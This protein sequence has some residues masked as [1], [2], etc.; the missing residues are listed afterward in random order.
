MDRARVT[1]EWAIVSDETMIVSRETGECWFLDLTERCDLGP[2]SVPMSG[3]G[4][5]GSTGA[6]LNGA[7]ELGFAPDDGEMKQSTLSLP[8]IV[9]DLVFSYHNANRAPGH[10]RTAAKRF[11]QLDRTRHLLVL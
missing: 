7:V 3:G 11:K 9:S 5:R 4:T 8:T 6:L 1:A 10:F 2:F